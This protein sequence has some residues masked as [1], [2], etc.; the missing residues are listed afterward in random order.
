[1]GH[2]F[3]ASFAILLGLLTACTT[4]NG[5]GTDAARPTHFVPLT[6]E[7]L[8]SWMMGAWLEQKGDDW[9]EE[10][11]TGPRGGIMLGASRTGKGDKLTMWEQAQIRPGSNG[12]LSFFAMPKG[13]APT[14]V[15]VTAQTAGSITFENPAH[16][17]PQ[18][19]KYWREGNLLK[20]EISMRD[21]SKAYGWTYKPMGV[22]M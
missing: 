3:K 14:E 17:Y 20:A 12:K 4:A 21:G 1:M 15:P 13:A 18:R 5:Q 9:V 10:Y 2:V 19:I 22:G 7:N 6:A 16:D 8:P 11:W